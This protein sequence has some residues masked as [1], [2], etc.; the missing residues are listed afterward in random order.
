MFGDK[1]EMNKSKKR[2]KIEKEEEKKLE[3]VR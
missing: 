2:K 3:D 1:K